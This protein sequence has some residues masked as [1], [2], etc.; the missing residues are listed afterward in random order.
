MQKILPL[1]LTALVGLGSCSKSKEEPQP[2]AASKTTL[3]VG[4]TWQWTAETLVVTPKAGGPAV[5]VVRPV[6]PGEWALTFD[7]NGKLVVKYKANTTES[8]YTLVGSV[9]TM[10]LSNSVDEIQALTTNR[11][12]LVETTEDANYRYAETDTFAR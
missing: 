6:T 5:T 7:A 10:A 9:L 2:A 4:G 12:V 11:L 1:F 3:L 8:T